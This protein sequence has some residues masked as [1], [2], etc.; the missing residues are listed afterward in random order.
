MDIGEEDNQRDNELIIK[1]WLH[2]VFCAMTSDR[3]HG[4]RRHV[5]PTPIKVIGR[6]VGA[7]G[8]LFP[9]SGTFHFK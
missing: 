7:K 8:R 5:M 6:K 1:D 9:S 4:R 2:S 3:G